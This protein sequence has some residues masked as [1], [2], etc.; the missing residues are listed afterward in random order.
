MKLPMAKYEPGKGSVLDASPELAAPSPV[1]PL[2]RLAPSSFR[3]SV[4]RTPTTETEILSWLSRISCSWE[5]QARDRRVN[6]P[7]TPPPI[8]KQL[9]LI[10]VFAPPTSVGGGGDP[11][12]SGERERA[13]RRPGPGAG[14]GWGAPRSPPPAAACDV[15]RVGGRGAARAAG[16]RLAG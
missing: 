2:R 16:R 9:L 10:I 11:G 3:T 13:A 7:R 8:R 4:N 6:H 12:P 5:P 14:S 15:P 1:L